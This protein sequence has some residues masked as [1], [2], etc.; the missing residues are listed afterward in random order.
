MSC[1]VAQSNSYLTMKDTFKGGNDV[2][3]FSINGFFCRAILNMADEHEFRDAITD[4][5]SVRFMVIP[6]G[7]F[8]RRKLSIG[9]FKKVLR[10]DSF[11]ELAHFRDRGDQVWLYLQENGKYHDRYFVLIDQKDDEVVAI[12]MKGH[13]DMDKLMS[14]KKEL[15]LN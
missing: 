12:E 15:A 13:V 2:H 10:S 8:E 9:G 5:K 7:E 11:H 14:L 6:K 4:I 1:A 3:S